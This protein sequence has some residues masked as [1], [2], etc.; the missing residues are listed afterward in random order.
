MHQKQPPAN[1]AFSC[2]PESTSSARVAQA[3][4]NMPEKATSNTSD[5]NIMLFSPVGNSGAVAP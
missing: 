4:A 5:L 3:K 2:E 1:V